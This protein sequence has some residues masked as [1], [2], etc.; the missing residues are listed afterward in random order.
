M[1]DG[2]RIHFSVEIKA[3]NMARRLGAPAYTKWQRPAHVIW[4]TDWKFVEENGE[5]LQ[6]FGRAWSELQVDKKGRAN[7]CEYIEINIPEGAPEELFI[8]VLAHEYLHLIYVRR[9]HLEPEFKLEHSVMLGESEKWV[10][11]LLG[12]EDGPRHIH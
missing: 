2:V 7:F 5:Q 10:R 11:K 6:N 9:R 1:P 8:E 12:Q 4:N 3:W